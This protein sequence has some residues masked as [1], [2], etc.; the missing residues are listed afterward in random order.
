MPARVSDFDPQADMAWARTA[1]EH[2]PLVPLIEASRC[3]MIEWLAAHPAPSDRYRAGGARFFGLGCGPDSDGDDD[4][5]GDGEDVQ[6]RLDALRRADWEGFVHGTD[7]A[8]AFTD[9]EHCA[10]HDY[11]FRRLSYAALQRAFTAELGGS[12]PQHGDLVNLGPVNMMCNAWVCY[13]PPDD[14]ALICTGG[15]DGDVMPPEVHDAPAGYFPGDHQEQSMSYPVPFLASPSCRGEVER[16]WAESD[17]A[18]EAAVTDVITAPVLVAVDGGAHTVGGYHASAAYNAEQL[19]ALTAA[20]AALLQRTVA[21]C[22]LPAGVLADVATCVGPTTTGD[23][24]GRRGGS[25]SGEP[26]PAVPVPAVDHDPRAHSKSQSK[27]RAAKAD[28]A[29]SLRAGKKHAK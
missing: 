13:G 29:A 25:G 12:R 3:K 8:R 15:E 26:E 28:T 11:D 27:Q 22:V 20:T 18:G 19:A 21:P 2:A 5:D 7:L 9:H 4:G 10:G 23:A 6:E 1:P 14:L 16:A 24:A 17:F